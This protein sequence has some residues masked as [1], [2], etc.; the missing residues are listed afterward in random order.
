MDMLEDES[1]VKADP[2]DA[3]E[4]EFGTILYGF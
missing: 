3:F 2:S 1:S 4:C